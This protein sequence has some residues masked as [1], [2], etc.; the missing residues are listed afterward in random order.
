MRKLLLVAVVGS[1][2]CGVRAQD[3]LND[4]RKRMIFRPGEVP[5]VATPTPA[6][7]VAQKTPPPAETIALFFRALQAGNVDAAYEALARGTIIAE[8]PE[9]VAE[10]KARTK[11]AIDNYGPVSGYETIDTLAAGASL[12]RQTCLSLNEDLPLRWR[13]YFYKGP[14][15]WKLVDLRVDDG[16]VELFEDVARDRKP[17]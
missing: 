4:P 16:L 9:N 15:G 3:D 17:Q 8:R 11:Q 12:L 7:S 14:A 13:F 6:P 2:I 1:G 5:V 10:L